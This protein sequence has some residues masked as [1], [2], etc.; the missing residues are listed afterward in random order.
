M[1]DANPQ[2]GFT[3]DLK[4]E[5]VKYDAFSFHLS[6]CLTL[7][8]NNIKST[9]K[10]SQGSEP[11]QPGVT[12]RDNAL[13]IVELTHLLLKQFK[14]SDLVSIDIPLCGCVAILRLL[15]TENDDNKYWQAVD[16]QLAE[17][18]TKY[19]DRTKLSKFIKRWI[20]DADFKLDGKV[21]LKYLSM[22]SVLPSKPERLPTASRRDSRARCSVRRQ[23]EWKGTEKGYI[24]R[25]HG[26][27][28][29]L[30][31]W[32]SAADSQH[33]ITRATD[34]QGL[35]LGSCAVDLQCALRSRHCGRVRRPLICSPERPQLGL[36]LHAAALPCAAPSRTVVVHLGSPKSMPVE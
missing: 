3:G 30:A 6:K 26:H 36:A 2:W 31:R 25:T 33:M 17:L 14:K 13:N 16:K 12:M 5:K 22:T 32:D 20:L 35:V 10:G 7:R 34:R 29:V 8:R 24:S 15:I 28:S 18:R 19:P 11:Q 4:T 27:A 23:H 21:D 1:L 9:V